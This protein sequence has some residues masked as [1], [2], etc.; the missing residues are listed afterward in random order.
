MN[1]GDLNNEQW[2]KLKPLLP[3]MKPQTGRPSHDHRQVINGILW[4]SALNKCGIIVK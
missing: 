4:G 3:P 1:R 2:E